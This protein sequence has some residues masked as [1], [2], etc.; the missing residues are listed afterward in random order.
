MTTTPRKQRLVVGIMVALAV[1]IFL[2]DAR[3]PL[4]W[5]PSPLF[6]AVVGASMWLPGLRPIF[7]SAFACTLLTVLGHFASSPG[8]I[9]ADLF[10]RA[11][12]ILAICVVA[13]F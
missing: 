13:L 2:L 8:P 3:M 4:G 7:I 11:C 5:V 9:D 1:L 6:V 10:N 12:S